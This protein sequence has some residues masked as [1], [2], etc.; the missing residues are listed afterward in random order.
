MVLKDPMAADALMLRYRRIAG[1][2]GEFMRAS[3]FLALGIG[4]AGCKSDGELVRAT[5][6]DTFFQVPTDAVDILW[7]IDNSLSM[8][9]EQAQV[10]E[11]FDDFIISLEKSEL[12]FHI[13]IVTTDLDHGDHRGKLVAPEGEDVYLSTETEDYSGKF[14][15][16]VLVGI[17]GAD[18]EKGID[19]AFNA[20]SEPLVSSWNLGFIREEATLSVIYV[21]DENDCTDRGSLAAYDNGLSCYEHSDDLVSMYDLID[22]Y[23]SLKTGG[24]RI[25]V[26]SIVGPDIV[27]NCEGSVPGDRYRTMTE[28]FGGIQGSICEENF[29]EIMNDLGLQVSGLLYSFQLSYLAIFDTL[30]VWIDEVS[31]VEDEENGWTYNDT[32][33]IL[34]F[35]GDGVPARGSEIVVSYEISGS[36]AE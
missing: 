35:H 5:Y 34:Y 21:S 3:V 33:G 26:S 7:V 16:R 9:D 20:L 36:L 8:A 17:D 29:S 27:E 4:L 15:D 14:K 31:V 30:E 22:D 19:A 12:D 2:R 32:Y 23:S 25:M 13:G 18:K 1:T 6:T 11:K 10:A 24:A 28:A